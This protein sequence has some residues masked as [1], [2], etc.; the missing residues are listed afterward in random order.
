MR[1]ER[2]RRIPWA[3]CTLL[4]GAAYGVW[5]GR[6][7]HEHYTALAQLCPQDTPPPDPAGPPVSII[8]PAR[9]EA[10]HLP[11]L[12]ASLS[13]LRYHAAG[14]ARLYETIVVDDAST[15]GGGAA[16][17]TLGAR[18]IRLEEADRPVGWTGK[19][20][21]CMRGAAVAQHA[22]LLF[23]DADTE[24][25]PPAVERVIAYATDRA[26]DALSLL[27][28]QRC[29]TFWERLLL[30]YAYQQLFAGLDPARLADPST[31]E[32]CLNGQFI[33]VRRAAYDA[34]GGHGAVRAC[35]V[36]D[37]ALARALKA[38]GCRLEIV[39]G[40][41]LG[42]VRMYHDLLSIKEGFGKN[43]FAFLADEP[44]RGVRVALASACAGLTVPSLALA[45]RATGAH[46]LAVFCCALLTWA[47]LTRELAGWVRR[48][49]APASYAIFQP[50]AAITFQAI[51]M[52]STV[53]SLS[54]HRVTWKGRSYAVRS[55]P[56][57]T[58]ETPET[59]KRAHETRR[60]LQP[61]PKLPLPALLGLSRS[62]L[63]RRRRSLREDGAS[64]V[65][66]L[67]G[68]WEAEGIEHIPAQGP[69]CLVLNHW[70]RRDLWIGWTGALIGE[71][72]TQQRPSA[73]PPVHWLVLS[74]LRLPLF[75]TERHLSGLDVF[76]RRVAYAWQMVPLSLAP[77]AAAQRGGALRVLA[78]L[79]ADGRVIG[80]FPEGHGGRAGPLGDPLPGV[81][82]FIAWLARQGVAIIPATTHET[83]G[84]LVAR[85]GPC[86]ASAPAL[87]EEPSPAH[88]TRDDAAAAAAVMHALA[89][90]LPPAYRGRW[91]AS[92]GC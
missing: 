74:E 42:S 18:V 21:A 87:A 68:R 82:R 91:H 55:A 7:S 19:A 29:E 16:A 88:L 34:I 77:R 69:V 81:G 10:E 4:A 13:T 17:A 57:G 2:P 6:R 25:T 52:E 92:K 46:R 90:L 27:L 76:L 32:A 40:E 23:L 83:R 84:K 78:R 45:A 64:V 35:I 65:H 56:P 67:A 38:A 86:L 60:F 33:L 1:P 43:A 59:P 37:V 58:P 36:E 41:Q 39:R 44:H 89:D 66:Q 9:N 47:G 80:F 70:Q 51:A 73:D 72:V 79:A 14:G 26:L 30:P 28:Q 31:G 12:L 8:I 61:P 54:G 53:R 11:R 48:F 20:N 49:G 75:G 22:W 3:L 5:S 62:I 50:L 85:F 71:L 15:D 24:L 63:R